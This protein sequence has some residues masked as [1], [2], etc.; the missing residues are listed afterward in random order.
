MIRNNS[1][2]QA[3]WRSAR[4]VSERRDRL[5]KVG[6]LVEAKGR[7]ELARS[8]GVDLLKLGLVAV[9]AGSCKTVAH[10]RASG[11][12]QGSRYEAYG[13][14]LAAHRTFFMSFGYNPLP[15]RSQSVPK[16]QGDQNKI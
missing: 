15:R 2:V 12:G 8:R 6:L 14:A 3:S 16:L 9:V 7:Q 1:G 11:V 13:Q 4:V 5:G 10:T